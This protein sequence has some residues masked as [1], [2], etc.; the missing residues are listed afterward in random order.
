MRFGV[1]GEG[2]DMALPGGVI[3]ELVKRVCAGFAVDC[4]SGLA[5]ID[6]DREFH[7]AGRGIPKPPA[8]RADSVR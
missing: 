2:P 5:V 1:S 6:F 8:F 4:G 7:F 3:A